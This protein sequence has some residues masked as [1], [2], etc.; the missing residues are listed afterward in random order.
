MSSTDINDVIL[1]VAV[2]FFGLWRVREWWVAILSGIGAIAMSFSIL[3]EVG[4]D[5]AA[6][7]LTF[8]ALGICLIGMGIFRSFDRMED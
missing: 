6:F 4:G 7:C 5:G 8:V 2:V 1:L 3:D